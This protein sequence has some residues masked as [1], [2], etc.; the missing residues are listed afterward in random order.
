MLT[1]TITMS[2]IMAVALT[3][4]QIRID[5]YKQK[6]IRYKKRINTLK[7][8]V[9]YQADKI[10]RLDGLLSDA[11]AENQEKGHVINYLDHFMKDEP[12]Y[13]EVVDKLKGGDE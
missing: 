3:A 9:E 5:F 11:Y 4:Q 1:F 2:A 7:D 13:I 12:K 6:S 10:K 8:S